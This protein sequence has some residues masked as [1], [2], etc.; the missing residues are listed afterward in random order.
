VVSQKP[1]IEMRREHCKREC[2]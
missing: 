1:S 2:R